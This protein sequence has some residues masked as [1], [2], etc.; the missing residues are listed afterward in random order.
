MLLAHPQCLYEAQCELLGRL[1]TPAQLPQLIEQFV[2]LLCF[3]RQMRYG[4][5]QR[6]FI[7]QVVSEFKA[8]PVV[9]DGLIRT[10]VIGQRLGQMTAD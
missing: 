4:R 6:E 2:V 7:A 9:F 5:D 8:P 1:V 10:V 3:D